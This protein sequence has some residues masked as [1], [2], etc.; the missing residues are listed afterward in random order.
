[1]RLASSVVL[2][3]KQ[4]ELEILVVVRSENLRFLSGFTAFPGGMTEKD[5]RCD[6]TRK[7]AENC[8]LRE[9]SEE[10]GLSAEV[11][12]SLRPRLAHIGTWM[13]PEYLVDDF[14]TY[15][16]AV[17]VDK[18][19]PTALNLSAELATLNGLLPD[20]CRFIKNGVRASWRHPLRQLFAVC[21]KAEG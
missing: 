11:V 10:L 12:E 1:M 2:Y 9:L 17:E 19:F 13:T 14:E 20:V 15:F 4:P 5:D 8:A 7:T 16:F 21:Q 6:S 18:D 3:R